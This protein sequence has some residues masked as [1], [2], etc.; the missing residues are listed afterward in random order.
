MSAAHPNTDKL[1]QMTCKGKQSARKQ[2]VRHRERLR[3]MVDIRIDPRLPFY[4]WLHRL[5]QE[6][7]R[8]R[9][10]LITEFGFLTTDFR[11][12]LAGQP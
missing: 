9:Q 7:M 12:K 3:R 6:R 8:Q 1:F 2:L 10:M 11:E 4:P 5:A